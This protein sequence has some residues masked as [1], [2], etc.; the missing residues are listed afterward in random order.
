MKVGIGI[1]SAGEWKSAFGLSLA[2][3]VRY[4][5]ALRRREETDLELNLIGVEGH[6]PEVRHRI[7]GE[8]VKD[9]CTH[10][11][12]LDADMTFPADTLMVLLR[13]NLP[14]VGANYPRRQMPPIPT[15][16]ALGTFENKD[17]GIVYS[18]GKTGVEEVKHVGM[19]VCLTDM[20]VYDA[21]DA[22][23]FAFEPTPPHFLSL[24]GEDVYFFEKLKREAGIPVYVDHDLSQMVSHVGSHA[25]T[26]KEAAAWRDARAEH[27]ATAAD[28]A[29]AA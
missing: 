15:T 10:L 3:M 12:W 1:P 26:M 29:S 18:D 17:H 5:Q 7:L 8:A 6:L 13:H 11:L 24:R 2:Y 25:F 19:G 27:A 28:Q 20:R 16:Y 9:D 21:I 14:V 22:P 23:Y 4:T